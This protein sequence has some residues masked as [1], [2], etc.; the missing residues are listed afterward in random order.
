VRE[1][2]S[3]HQRGSMHQVRVCSITGRKDGW[4]GWGN[5]TVGLSRG[6]F[7]LEGRSEV[8]GVQAAEHWMRPRA[9]AYGSTDF[10][11]AL[12]CPAGYYCPE[13][14]SNPVRKTKMGYGEGEGVSKRGPGR[15][16]VGLSLRDPAGEPSRRRAA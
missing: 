4:L 10:N 14:I 2:H 1:Q 15:E 12:K 13:D 16:R 11:K 3:V 9:R 7:F 5:S 8:G 6:W